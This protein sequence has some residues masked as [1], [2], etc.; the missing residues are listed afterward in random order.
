[1]TLRK[2]EADFSSGPKNHSV[3]PTLLIGVFVLGILAGIF[4]IAGW[5]S[6][7]IPVALFFVLAVA[8]FIIVPVIDSNEVEAYNKQLKEYAL[9]LQKHIQTEY[10]LILNPNQLYDLVT[11]KNT[12]IL[13]NDEYSL[14]HLGHK[15]DGSVILLHVDGDEFVNKSVPQIEKHDKVE[16]DKII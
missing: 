7:P 4:V 2:P 9:S 13:A 1:M 3:A 15:D 12:S 8:A 5:W 11:G 10:A 14:G 6:H 16:Y